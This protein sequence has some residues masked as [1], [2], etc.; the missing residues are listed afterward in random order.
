MKYLFDTYNSCCELGD[1][2]IRVIIDRLKKFINIKE[3]K[4][5]LRYKIN[6]IVII[7]ILINSYNKL[8]SIGFLNLI[9]N[10]ERL[11]NLELLS[12]KLK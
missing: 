2:D 1:D 8:S 6:I 7:I 10:L 9:E 12:I 11:I 4:L 5:D 3:L